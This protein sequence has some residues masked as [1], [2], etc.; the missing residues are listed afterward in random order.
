MT[1]VYNYK[2]LILKILF[3]VAVAFCLAIPF[4]INAQAAPAVSNF[5]ITSGFATNKTSEITFDSTRV[6][7]GTA[8]KGAKISITIY[9]PYTNSAGKTAYKL[10]RTYNLTV[11]ST[12]I[13][14]QSISLK[15]GVNYL[16]VTARKDGK[17]SEIRTTI[18]RKNKVLKSVLSQSIA[19]PGRGKW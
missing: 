15:E 14:S 16:V 11:G 1:F 19:V 9:E 7:S 12:G 3:V 17:Y 18:N 13:F 6:I 2:R 8:E 4:S 5:K 10:I